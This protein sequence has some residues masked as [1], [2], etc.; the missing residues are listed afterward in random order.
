VG[1]Q[2][3]VPSAQR[4]EPVL[5]GQH[6]PLESTAVI[7]V[8]Q[9]KRKLNDG[10]SG[11]GTGSRI[12]FSGQQLPRLST[13]CVPDGQHTSRDSI[14]SLKTTSLNSQQRPKSSKRRLPT[15]QQKPFSLTSVVSSRQHS[16]KSLRIKALGGQH[17]SESF[18]KPVP[19]GQQVPSIST[20]LTPSAQ[21]YRKRS[22]VLVKF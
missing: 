13:S 11:S 19:A 5:L 22:M 14:G 10:S 15:G 7:P 21:Q 3:V 2:S 9:Q 16:P 4:M 6:R 20:T 1:Q 12:S 17:R 8:G 18:K